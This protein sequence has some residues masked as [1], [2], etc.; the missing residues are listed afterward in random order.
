MNIQ[1]EYFALTVDGRD[2]PDS[3]DYW[4]ANWLICTAEI[5]AGNF[6]DRLD[7]SLRTDEPERFH[8]QVEQLDQRLIGDAKLTTMEDWLTLRLS[9]DHRG[10][11]KVNCRLFD[12]LDAA[13]NLLEV[14]PCAGS[15]IPEAIAAA[16]C[17]GSGQ[18]PGRLPA[19]LTVGRPNPSR[20]DQQ[21]QPIPIIL[22]GGRTIEVTLRA[23]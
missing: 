4:D 13:G 16:A 5:A 10:H 20:G 19:R 22:N 21:T 2:A 11:V 9:G 12:D 15:D 3:S 23:E 8:Q 18:V 6:H 14:S 1:A 7:S 17:G